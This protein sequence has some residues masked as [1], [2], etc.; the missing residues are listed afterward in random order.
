M[1][2]VCLIDKNDPK[3]IYLDMEAIPRIGE[4]VT[5]MEE[6]RTTEYIVTDVETTI[7]YTASSK[8]NQSNTSVDYIV[9]LSKKEEYTQQIFPVWKNDKKPAKINAAAMTQ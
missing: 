9:M 1:I 8:K 2:K 3:M 6:K 5:I 7:D 4:S